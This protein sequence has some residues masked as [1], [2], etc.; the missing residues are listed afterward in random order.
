MRAAIF[1]VILA[2]CVG[3][4]RT[5]EPPVLEIR[6]PAFAGLGGERAICDNLVAALAHR[7]RRSFIAIVESLPRTPGVERNSERA[8]DIYLELL[9][10]FAISTDIVDVRFIGRG[11]VEGLSIFIYEVE[12][13]RLSGAFVSEFDCGLDF[14]EGKGGNMS[15][16]V[17]FATLKRQSTRPI[18]ARAR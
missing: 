1:A 15:L 4:C 14:V 9:E 8:A 13:I 17:S 3:A 6:R 11:V 2:L 10:R 7:D 18:E 16:G 12:F 5:V